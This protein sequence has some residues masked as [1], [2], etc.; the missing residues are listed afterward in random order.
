MLAVLAGGA[1]GAPARWAIMQHFPTAPDRFPVTTCAINVVGAF[2][3]GSALTLFFLHFA[4]APHVR[5]AVSTGGLGAFT[6][7][8]ALTTEVVT[9]VNAGHVGLAVVYVAVSVLAG[10]AAAGLGIGVTHRALRFPR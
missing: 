10:V 2:A 7:F 8:S 5:L 6:T 4:S 3:L 9:R 1:V